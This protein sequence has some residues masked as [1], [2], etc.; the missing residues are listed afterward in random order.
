VIGI[1]G[2]ILSLGLEENR[3]DALDSF[4]QRDKDG[5]VSYTDLELSD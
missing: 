4:G 1:T 3:K 2:E 5:Q